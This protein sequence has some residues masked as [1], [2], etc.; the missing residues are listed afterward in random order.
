MYRNK[1]ILAIVP[2]RGGSKG[3]KLK[4]LKKINK[5]SLTR[6]VGEFLSKIK[7]IDYSIISTDNKKI[8]DEAKKYNLEYFFK[9]PKKLS[10]DLV[11]D[12][13]VVKHA[14][15]KAEKY[16]KKNFDI[17]LLLQPTSPLR[18]KKHIKNSLDLLIDN[19]AD[20]VWTCSKINTKYHPLK[21]LQ[22]TK[23]FLKPFFKKSLK[24]I[25]RQQL[26][27]VYIRNGVCYTVNRNTIL[28]YQNL[29]GKKC[30]PLVIQEKVINIDNPKDLK[31]AEKILKKS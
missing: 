8:A 7:Y 21:V 25:A 1:K 14:L 5:K 4:N 29:F 9:R 19:N 30:I 15:I 13:A 27:D 17:I 6:I 2:A 16:K 26:N 22:I 31:L 20:S 12:H 28:N 24:V 23:N 11:S 3:I 10:G 18:T